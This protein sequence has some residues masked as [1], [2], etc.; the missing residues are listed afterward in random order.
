[1]RN[2]IVYAL[3]ALVVVCFSVS[4]FAVGKVREQSDKNADAIAFVCST[5]GVLD[6]L[7]KSSIESSE[8]S[9]ANGAYERLVTQG[10]LTQEDV[11]RAQTQLETFRAGHRV[12][13]ERN[14]R[15][16]A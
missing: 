4:A 1:M 11:A 7:V 3:I 16:R 9:F 8:L 10:V 6:T 14:K 5:T 12:L 13:A 15:C 2:G